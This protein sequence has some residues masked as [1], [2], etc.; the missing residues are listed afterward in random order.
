MSKFADFKENTQKSEILNNF[1]ESFCKIPL[2]D[3]LPLLY[4]ALL[5]RISELEDINERFKKRFKIEHE[6]AVKEG[7]DYKDLALDARNAQLKTL[8]ELADSIRTVKWE[9]Y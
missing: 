6:C 9:K 2:Y 1:Y 5:I 8:K 3:T 4:E 7:L